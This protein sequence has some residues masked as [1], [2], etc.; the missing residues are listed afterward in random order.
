VEEGRLELDAPVVRYLPWWDGGD[1]DKATVTVRQLLL[2][3]A[4]LIPFRTFFYDMDGRE[5]Y[6][7]AIAAE[8]L[9]YAPG[10]STVYSDLG[11]ITLGWIIEELT[12]MELDD[13]LAERVFGPLGMQDTGFLPAPHL[14]PRIAPTEVDTTYRHRHVHGTVHDENAHAL[15]GVAGHAGLFS[16]ARDLSVFAQM[17]LNGGRADPC[18][19]V[20]GSGVPCS[21]PLDDGVRIVRQS[22][23]DDFVSR[24]DDASPRGLGW[25]TPYQGSPAGEFFTDTGFGHTGYTGTSIFIDRELDLFVV[26]L[27]SRVNPTRENRKHIPLRRAVHD[28]AALAISDRAVERRRW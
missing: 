9:I 18:T 27:T 25:Y 20:T 22:T 6:Q 10:D 21:R 19:G 13:F 2:H 12:G 28:L 16:S 5:A 1:P 26:L 24:H 3:R 11:V 15:G 7:E 14:L 8:K 4:G 23:I 17:M